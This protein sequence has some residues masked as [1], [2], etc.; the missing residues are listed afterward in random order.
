MYDF[1]FTLYNAKGII[2][3]LTTFM[4]NLTI[5]FHD[6]KI[7]RGEIVSNREK[8]RGTLVGFHPTIGVNAIFRRVMILDGKK[9]IEAR[10]PVT[11]TSPTFHE[12]IIIILKPARIL[13][14][15]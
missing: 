10:L 2:G 5:Y 7:F 3:A 12:D 9:P 8:E 6:R 1:P 4:G 14:N 11:R 13:I 15:P